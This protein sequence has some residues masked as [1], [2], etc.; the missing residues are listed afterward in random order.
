M[1]ALWKWFK[2]TFLGQGGISTNTAATYERHHNDEHEED[3]DGGHQQAAG[4]D[5]PGRLQDSWQE[6]AKTPR[7]GPRPEHVESLVA[8][9]QLTPGT[10][11]W[12]LGGSEAWVLLA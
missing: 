4:S 7:E 6:S 9:K 10:F 8:D 1:S 11:L 2:R 12:P 3:L 5:V